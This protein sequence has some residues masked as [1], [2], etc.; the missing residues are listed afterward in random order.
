MYIIVH[1]D[2]SHCFIDLAGR[3]PYTAKWKRGHKPYLVL[4]RPR[5]YP[6]HIVPIPQS[7]DQAHN[8][9]SMDEYRVHYPILRIPETICQPTDF[10]LCRTETAEL[11]R[12]IVSHTDFAYIFRIL[13]SQTYPAD[14]SRILI[15]HTYSAYL[16]RILIS[17]TYFTYLF[18]KLIP[19]IYSTYLFHK[20]TS[21]TYFTYSFRILILHTYFTQL[22]HILISH[23]YFTNLFH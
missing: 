4:R 6:T 23:T 21:Q 12:R 19:Q 1:K 3:I 11:S 17:H 9:Y 5:T 8:A 7:G 14:L 2:A 20:L 16:F 15:S 18:H 13:I 10:G 22:F